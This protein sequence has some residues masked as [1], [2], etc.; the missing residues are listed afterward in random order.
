MSNTALKIELLMEG[1]MAPVQPAWIDEAVALLPEAKSEIE[2]LRVAL[3][4]IQAYSVGDPKPRHTWYYDRAE[5]A[6]NQQ[7]TVEEPK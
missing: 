5:T 1:L 2:R 3:K 6:L 7:L 4:E